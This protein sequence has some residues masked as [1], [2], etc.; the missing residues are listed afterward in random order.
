MTKLLTILTIRTESTRLPGKILAP[1]KSRTDGKRKQTEPFVTWILRR[2]AQIENSTTVVATTDLKSDDELAA[3]CEGEGVAVV[4]GP[5]D[6]VVSRMHLAVKDYPKARYVI[7]A[8]GDCPFLDTG[9]V[10]YAVKALEE[11]KKEALVYCLPPDVISVYGSR[12]F[13]YS[14][15]AW[16]RINDNSTHR[17]HSDM[18]FHQ[19]REHFNVLYH[20]GPDNIYMRPYR[21]EVDTPMDLELIRAIADEVGM[22]ADLKDVIK[23]LDQ[24]PDLAK[25]NATIPEKTGPLSLATYSNGQRRRW[26]MNMVGKSVYTWSGE[27]VHPVDKR[28]TPIM[29]HCGELIGW[30]WKSSLYM[31]DGTRLDRGFPRCRACGVLVREW[32]EAIQPS[33]WS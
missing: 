14:R 11:T 33:V 31:R 8:L 29:C 30:G 10:S 2:L 5:V 23:L 1:V 15:V 28:A 3:L 20:M 4:R 25:I 13:P 26:M 32:K 7:R 19:N 24:R 22:L 27:W 6:D 17:E 16:E 9:I 18:Y 12:E 21:L